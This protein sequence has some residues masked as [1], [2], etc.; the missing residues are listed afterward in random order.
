MQHFYILAHI[1]GECVP[2]PL[3]TVVILRRKMHEHSSQNG[4]SFNFWSGN[5][6]SE[7]KDMPLVAAFLNLENALLCGWR[8][9]MEGWMGWN[10]QKYKVF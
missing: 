1:M 10:G 4:H 7:F 9:W 6:F 8:G 5:V 2:Y 3:C